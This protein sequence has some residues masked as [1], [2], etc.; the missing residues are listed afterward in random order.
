M[1]Q[2]KKS[3]LVIAMPMRDKMTRET[4]LALKHN[5]P[6]HRLVTVTGLPVDEAR[7]ELARQVLALN[8][9]PKVIVS[10]DDD[11]YWDRGAVEALTDTLNR[12]PEYAMVTAAYSPRLPG[13][14]IAAWLSTDPKSQLAPVLPGAP[15]YGKVIPIARCGLH[16]YAVRTDALRALGADPYAV[17]GADESFSFCDRLIAKGFRIGCATAVPFAHCDVTTGLAFL[18]GAPPLKIENGIARVFVRDGVMEFRGDGRSYGPAVD[19]ALAEQA[20]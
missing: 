2:T 12:L 8:P 7:N 18:P 14:P 19:A 4:E 16:A 17:A 20:A 9:V 1:I 3:A 6:P 11:A 10:I 15:N 13:A 5:T